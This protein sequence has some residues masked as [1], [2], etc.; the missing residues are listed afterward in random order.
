[1]SEDRKKRTAVR[2]REKIMQIKSAKEL[3][4]YKKGYLLAMEVFPLSEG[5]PSE[6]KFTIDSICQ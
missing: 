2:S 1:M 4:V 5:F 6:D 3:E